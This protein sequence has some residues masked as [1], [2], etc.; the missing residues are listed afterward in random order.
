[1]NKY[2]DSIK[3]LVTIVVL[4]FF[5]I[6]TSA[7]TSAKSFI[8][9]IVTPNDPNAILLRPDS[10]VEGLGEQW[11]NYY[12]SRIVRNV[13]NPTLTPFL[14]D[15]TKAT[16]VAV[17]IAPGGG[18]MDL[19]IDGEGY[20]VARWLADHGVAAFVLKY[21]M[22]PTQRDPQAFNSDLMKFLGELNVANK[23]KKRLVISTPEYT[24][25]DAK[26]AVRL[27]RSRA[28]EWHIDPTRVGFIGFSAGAITTLSVGLTAEAV[29]RPDFIAPIYGPMYEIEVPSYAPAAF[30]AIA[31]DDPIFGG[32]CCGLITAWQKAKRPVEAHLYGKGGHGFATMKRGLTTD[33]WLDEFYAWMKS[34]RLLEPSK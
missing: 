14:P 7:Q 26:T 5:T 25:D 17:I 12:G 9:E 13:V 15:P 29:D 27:V 22:N 31:L 18:F 21:R 6:S 3:V 23:E 19:Y 24:L 11:N 28:A 1:M 16:G 4:I 2:I 32:D 33:M 20:Q 30:M 10:K 34:R 8:E